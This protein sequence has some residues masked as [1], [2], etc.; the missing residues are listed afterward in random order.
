MQSG[1]IC[2]IFFR[3]VYLRNTQNNP[4]LG[5]YWSTSVHNFYIIDSNVSDFG[6]PLTDQIIDINLDD[7]EG[8][9]NRS[10]L[11]VHVM[12]ASFLNRDKERLTCSVSEDLRLLLVTNIPREIDLRER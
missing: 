9:M 12:N 3:T 5:A 7:Y 10:N 8:M 1:Y 4:R 2:K 11:Q 6:L